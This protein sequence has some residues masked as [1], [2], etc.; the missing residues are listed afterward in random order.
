MNPDRARQVLARERERIEQAI[1]GLGSED[2]GVV[3]EQDEPG[4]RGSENLYQ[5]EFEEQQLR[6][7]G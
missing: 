3:A 6:G 2:S 7:R 5:N 4:D 1:A